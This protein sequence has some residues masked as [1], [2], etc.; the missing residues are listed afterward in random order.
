MKLRNEVKIGLITIVALGLGYVGINFLK[1]INLFSSDNTYYVRLQ[2]LG[3][4]DVASPL[5]INGYKVGSVRDVRFGYDD[6]EGYSAL[7]TLNLSPEVRLPRGSRI[8]VKTNM[9]SG[10]ELILSTDSL[11]SGFYSPGDTLTAQPSGMDLMDIATNQVVPAVMEILPELTKTLTRLN[12]IV[13]NPVIDSSM[14]NLHTSTVE[15]QRMMAQ[16]SKATQRMPQVMGNV[17]QMTA[18]M[19]TVGKHAEGLKLDDIVANLN[20]TTANLRRMTQQL[21]STDNTAGLLLNDA[22]LYNRL[23]SLANSADALMKDLKANPKRY[24]HFSVF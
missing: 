8:R 22:R 20:E 17:E 12:E 11:T 23:D 5:R 2:D 6:R 21:Q 15:L 19:A 18:S 4:V 14:L 10:A 7:V 3:G 16:L 24:V 9:L 13:S 1:G